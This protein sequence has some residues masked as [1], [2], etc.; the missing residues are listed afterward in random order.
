MKLKTISR[1]SFLKGA[2]V[3][4]LAVAA[5]GMM[6]A[7]GDSSSSKKDPVTPT[8]TPT[9]KEVTVKYVTGGTFEQV[10]CT[11]TI[12]VDVTKLDA[13]NPTIPSSSLTVPADFSAKW[14]IKSDVEEWPIQ[15][16]EDGNYYV[17]VF[18]EAKHVA[19]DNETVTIKYTF[20]TKGDITANVVAQGAKATVEV[21]A[22]SDKLS[23]AGL[24][25]S[26]ATFEYEAKET[27]VAIERKATNNGLVATV[28]LKKKKY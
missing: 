28:A 5:A 13:A 2:G 18:V 4:A 3:T 25:P 21:P 9:T 17:T 22:G 7:C 24:L 19:T 16:A 6:T 1:R 23:T 20:G 12:N 15:K 26:Q 8:P 27:A 10:V 11:D 14:E